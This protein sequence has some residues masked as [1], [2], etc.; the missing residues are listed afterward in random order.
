MLWGAAPSSPHERCGDLLHGAQRVRREMVPQ[1]ADVI[2]PRGADRVPPVGVSCELTRIEGMLSTVVLRGDAEVGVELV[3]AGDELTG[4][5]E[6]L[7]VEQRLRKPPALAREPQLRL[8]EGLGTVTHVREHRIER[9]PSHRSRLSAQLFDRR[10][11]P[12]SRNEVIRRGDEVVGRP[13]SRGLHPR[14]N[15]MLDRQAA[16]HAARR[17]AGLEAVPD[18]TPRGRPV[19]RTIGA[20]M[21][22]RLPSVGG[23]S[24]GQRQGGVVAEELPG[25]QAGCVALRQ[26]PQVPELG[27]VPREPIL[28]FGAGPARLGGL[29]DTVERAPKRRAAHH[30]P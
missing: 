15:R 25:P 28:G 9:T 8:A 7:D 19:T 2:P 11:A 24:R 26:Q 13:C 16:D 21:Q 30:S 3:D 22:D 4:R 5:T 18:H 14:A 10:E 20:H 23:G 17:L 27:R 12:L 6:Q 29:A 1:N